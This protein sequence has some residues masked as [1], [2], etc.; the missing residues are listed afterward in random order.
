MRKWSPLVLS[1]IP[2]IWAL[3]SC[4]KHYEPVSYPDHNLNMKQK[5]ITTLVSHLD[6]LCQVQWTKDKCWSCPCPFSQVLSLRW[7]S[8]WANLGCDEWWFI[9]E[10][11]WW[12][13]PRPMVY[14]WGCV[15]AGNVF[16]HSQT[17]HFP[18]TIHLLGF[19]HNLWRA[20]QQIVKW[21]IRNTV[22]QLLVRERSMQLLHRPMSFKD[23]KN[24]NVLL[25]W[26]RNETTFTSI[27]ISLFTQKNCTNKTQLWRFSIA[28]KLILLKPKWEKATN[29]SVLSSLICDFVT[30]IYFSYYL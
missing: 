24:P 30:D 26:E 4:R 12:C 14:E 21:S 9:P 3:H 1:F 6:N 28:G 16:R 25:I 11:L 27:C 8:F 23:Q 20:C 18:P 13:F 17:L 15:S 29:K 7:K 10:S 22:I 5:R 2:T 19:N